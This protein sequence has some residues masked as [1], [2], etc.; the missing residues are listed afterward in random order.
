[1]YEYTIMELIGTM[2]KDE[3]GRYAVASWAII[4]IRE[5][6]VEMSSLNF[7]IQRTK[8]WLMRNLT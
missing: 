6:K 1:M 4:D 8:L 5:E 2:G 7:T 3:N